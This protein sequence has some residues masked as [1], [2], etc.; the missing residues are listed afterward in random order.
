MNTWFNKEKPFEHTQWVVLLVIALLLPLGDEDISGKSTSPFIDVLA[1][2]PSVEAISSLKEDGVLQGYQDG[3]FRPE[4]NINRAEFLTVVIQGDSKDVRGGNCFL[5]VHDEWFAPFVCYAKTV[6]IVTGFSDGYFRPGS[7]IAFSAAAKILVVHAGLSVEARPIWYEPYVEKLRDAGAIPHTITRMDQNVSRAELAD[8]VY[9]FRK[10]RS[11]PIKESAA[12]ERSLQPSSQH[13]DEFT[14][15]SSRI[16]RQAAEWIFSL[17][18]NRLL[19]SHLQSSFLYSLLV[20]NMN[21]QRN[22]HSPQPNVLTKNDWLHFH[23]VIVSSFQYP[24]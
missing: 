17:E 1:D 12:E 6:Q 7:S 4:E 9:Q 13:V 11:T 20:R 16:L 22:R 3:T 18:N 8:M 23:R 2:H 21:H 19:P 14:R 5:D 24:L 10:Y 15:P